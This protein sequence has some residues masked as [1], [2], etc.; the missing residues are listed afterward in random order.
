MRRIVED[1]RS[2]GEPFAVV[3]VLKPGIGAVPILRLAGGRILS[4]SR[5]R[6][7]HR[8]HVVMKWRPPR[9][10]VI[11]LLHCQDAALAPCSFATT[12]SRRRSKPAALIGD[13]V[14][15][16]ADLAV[17]IAECARLIKGYGDTHKRGTLNY[18]IIENR[19][20]RPVLDRRITVLQGTDAI[21]SART[22]ALLDPDGESLARC[23]DDF[24]AQ[25]ALRI[26]AE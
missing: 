14:D 20:I 9:S 25:G 21:A 19:I 17:E 11:W 15:T 1:S 22:A 16:V 23:L 4:L 18:G 2:A 12:R 7:A 8:F 24:D 5:A 6:L 3:E 26:A 13:G 10:P